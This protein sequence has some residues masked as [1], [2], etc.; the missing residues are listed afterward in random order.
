LPFYSNELEPDV[1]ISIYKGEELGTR[2]LKKLY[3]QSK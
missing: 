2:D 3:R 1:P